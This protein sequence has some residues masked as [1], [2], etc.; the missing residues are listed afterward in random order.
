MA[1]GPDRIQAKDR[2]EDDLSRCMVGHIT[3]A[4]RNVKIDAQCPERRR[5]SV[6]VLVAAPSAECYHR[7]VL[8]LEHDIRDLIRDPGLENVLL[9]LGRCRVSDRTGKEDADNGRSAQL[10]AGMLCLYA[11]AV[12]R[13]SRS[14]RSLR[15]ILKSQPSP[16]GSLLRRSGCPSN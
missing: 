7:K 11:S 6:Q 16:Y 3:A 10:S 14:E 4:G 15:R 5:R 12:S 1:P 13:R 8:H 9:K 2:I